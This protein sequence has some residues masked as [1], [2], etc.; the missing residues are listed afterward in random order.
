M[1]DDLIVENRSE[2]RENNELIPTTYTINS[3][4]KVV[5][6]ADWF[7]L[8]L[9]ADLVGANAYRTRRYEDQWTYAQRG[10][11]TNFS[12]YIRTKA[13]LTF[14]P[15]WSTGLKLQPA[16]TVYWKGTEDLREL[17]TSTGP[18]GNQIP[19]ILAGTVERTVRPSLYLRYQPAGMNLFG[20][21]QD[22][23]F[24]LWLDADMGVN[25][26]ENANNVEGATDSRFIGLFRFAGQFTF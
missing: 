4:I 9:E 21:D 6:I 23:R 19:G 3:T 13:S 25:F 7:D 15:E 26:V 16:V 10:L 14:Y 11:A 22:V 17:R 12:D 18:D 20:D 8:G 1:L 24:N 2:L 5:D